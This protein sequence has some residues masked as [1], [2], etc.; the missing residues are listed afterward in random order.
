LIAILG[1]E[2]DEA[3]CELA[4]E[5]SAA[6]ALLI[7]AQDLC[8]HG[9]M[10]HVPHCTRDTFVAGGNTY[11]VASLDAVLVRR[12]AVVAEELAWIA[13]EDRVYVASE[14]NAFLIAWLSALPCAVLNRPSATS[15]CGPGW[16][17]AYWEVAAAR[18]GI[19]WAHTA[20][21]KD[22]LEVVFCGYAQHGGAS[23]RQQ[24]I[25][26]QLMAASGTDLL[27]VRFSGEA[28][29]A[30]SSQP[31]LAARPLRDLVLA[32]LQEAGAA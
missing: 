11:P 2:L 31:R 4:A 24:S 28:V 8:T 29:E 18:A 9:W 21:A 19:A 30:V 20:D 7:S 15:L 12:P 26:R 23:N 32:H 5:W 6:G 10:F 14:I 13:E 25:G 17:Q 22:S 1:S 27:A 16:P 3:A